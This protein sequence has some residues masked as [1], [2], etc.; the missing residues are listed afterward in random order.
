MPQLSANLLSESDCWLWLFGDR[1]PPCAISLQSKAFSRRLSV[2]HPQPP[3]HC[4]YLQFVTD[5]KDINAITWQSSI[6]FLKRSSCLCDRA[7]SE[8]K[9]DS[10]CC[11]LS[12][13]CCLS[14]N[15][16]G[17]EVGFTLWRRPAF[18]DVFFFFRLTMTVQKQHLVFNRECLDPLRLR[19]LIYPLQ[20]QSGST[21]AE[22][23]FS[24]WNICAKSWRTSQQK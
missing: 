24:A 2:K 15:R 21:P 22:I 8:L 4:S 5:C 3:G 6:Y 13:L 19:T 17:R 16:R 12:K 9:F 11:N 18:W 20:Q 1:L 7:I 14:K 23:L 10:Y